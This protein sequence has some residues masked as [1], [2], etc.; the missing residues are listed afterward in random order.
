MIFFWVLMFINLLIVFTK[1]KKKY[2]KVSIVLFFLAFAF[3]IVGIVTKDPIFEAFGVPP[4]FEWVVGLF[5]TGFTSWKIYLN[6]LKER[7]IG[8]ETNVASLKS[9]V[10]SN[11]SLI[12]SDLDLIK[13]KLLGKK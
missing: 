2:E 12:K 5:I 1:Y 10:T 3:L 9:D 13:N 8:V 6:P 4:E 7:I 11:F